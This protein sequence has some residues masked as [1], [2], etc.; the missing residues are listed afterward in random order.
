MVWCGVT[1]T[2]NDLKTDPYLIDVWMMYDLIFSWVVPLYFTQDVKVPGVEP[3]LI[4]GYSPGL[5][6]S[7]KSCDLSSERWT[8]NGGRENDVRNET[9]IISHRIHVFIDLHLVAS[10]GKCQQRCRTLIFWVLT[11][12][13]IM[14]ISV[15][16][17]YTHTICHTENRVTCLLAISALV[18]QVHN[19][20]QRNNLGLVIFSISRSIRTLAHPGTPCGFCCGTWRF[21]LDEK[22]WTIS[23]ASCEERSRRCSNLQSA[24]WHITQVVRLWFGDSVS[25]LD[26]LKG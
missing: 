5:A 8:S 15:F 7:R 11:S 4:V 25:L 1:L 12:K 17:V 6:L 9:W 18:Y 2:P 14:Y 21:R 13:C 24:T 20:F 3:S 19:T 10:H 22:N 26:F 23:T 16:V